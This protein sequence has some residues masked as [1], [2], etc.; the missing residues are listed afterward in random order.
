LADSLIDKVVAL[1]ARADEL[2]ERARTQAKALQEETARRLKE[3][4]A[5]YQGELD[6]QREALREKMEHSLKQSLEQEDRRFTDL[7]EQISRE[8]EPQVEAAS[9]E[10]VRRF[11]HVEPVAG[12]G[13]GH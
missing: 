5:H 6:H 8:A 11:F 1:E 2:V 12:G 10:V 9:G 7:E 13:D 3:L 4:Q